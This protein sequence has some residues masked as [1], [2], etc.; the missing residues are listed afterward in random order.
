MFPFC[1]I[2]LHP[3]PLV[4]NLEILI[5]LISSEVNG[6][7]RIMSFSEYDVLNFFDIWFTNPSFVPKYTLILF[8]ETKGLA[9]GYIPVNLLELLIFKLTLTNISRKCQVHF[10]SDYSSVNYQSQV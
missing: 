1:Y 3:V 8:S 4:G 6:V 9:F 2:T 7:C 5:H 10:Y